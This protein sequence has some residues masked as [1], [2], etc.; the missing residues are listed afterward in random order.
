MC[1]ICHNRHSRHF[2]YKQTSNEKLYL[3]LELQIRKQSNGIHWEALEKNTNYMYV[4]KNKYI[5]SEQRKKGDLVL[6]VFVLVGLFHSLTGYWFA[7][8]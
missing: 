7:C 8:V 2:L 5:K 4:V 6:V 1:K 3:N